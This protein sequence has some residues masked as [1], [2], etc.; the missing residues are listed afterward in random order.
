MDVKLWEFKYNAVYRLDSYTVKLY[1]AGKKL[2][3]GATAVTAF[4][5]FL[6][7]ICTIQLWTPHVITF[8][9]FV[10]V[11]DAMLAIDRTALNRVITTETSSFNSIIQIL[12]PVISIETSHE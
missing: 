7:N 3:N 6:C 1:Y 8:L 11:D 4:P 9:S 2:A 10:T 12:F 5:F